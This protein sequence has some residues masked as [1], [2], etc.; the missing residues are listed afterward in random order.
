MADLLLA[1]RPN[2]PTSWRAQWLTPCWPTLLCWPKHAGQHCLGQ[3]A[4]H[5][6]LS[7]TPPHLP[8]VDNLICIMHKRRKHKNLVYALP[9]C[10]K[11]GWSSQLRKIFTSKV[12]MLQSSH[13]STQIITSRLSTP[14]HLLP[15]HDASIQ[16][17]KF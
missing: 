3:H 7:W 2:W 8:W 15:A 10:A 4:F 1:G 13:H 5:G 12:Y 17:H 16:V 6:Q 14:T 9:I 11:M